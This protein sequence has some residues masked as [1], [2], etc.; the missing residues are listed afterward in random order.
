VVEVGPHIYIPFVVLK[1]EEPPNLTEFYQ[2]W[3]PVL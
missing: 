1:K 2:G 3:M